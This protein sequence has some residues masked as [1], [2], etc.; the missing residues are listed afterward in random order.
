MIKIDKY[1]FLSN[2]VVD[3]QTYLQR[4]RICKNCEHFKKVVNICGECICFIPA[5]AR[6]VESSCPLDKWKSVPINT[7]AE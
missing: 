7:K 4:F 5:K 1:G 6:H 3:K 2:I